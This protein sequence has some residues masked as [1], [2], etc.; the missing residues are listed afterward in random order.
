[1]AASINKIID[2]LEAWA[3][4]VTDEIGAAGIYVF[5]SLMHRSG[6]QFGPQS[7]VDL[8]V[9]IPGGFTGAYQ[10]AEWLHALQQKKHTLEVTLAKLLKRAD[11]NKQICSVIAV[12]TLELAAN[13]HKSG[14]PGFFTENQ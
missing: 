7:D 2:S 11:L 6:A 14:S 8:V 9:I 5:G 4:A 12:T 10:R 13:I 1:M 3:N